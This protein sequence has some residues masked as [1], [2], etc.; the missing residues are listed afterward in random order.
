MPRY[1]YFCKHCAAKATIK[2]GRDLTDEESS[3]FLFETRHAMFPS[4][5]ELAEATK[6]P[7]CSNTD[8]EK[9]IDASGQLAFIRGHDWQEFKKKNKAALSRDMALH[10]LKNDDPYGYM[11]S[12]SDK[13]ELADKIKSGATKKPK[14]QYFIGTSKQK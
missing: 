13:E 11:R 7:D 8:V 5:K 14:P 2:L 1:N 9:M 12:G 4:D 6:C 3:E 10:Q